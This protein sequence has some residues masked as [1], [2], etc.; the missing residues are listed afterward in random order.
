MRGRSAIAGGLALALVIIAGTRLLSDWPGAGGN[1]QG[2]GSP[3]AP[4]STP[5]PTWPTS[6]VPGHDLQTLPRFPNAVRTRYVETL[7]N[8]LTLT[9]VEYLA[10]TQ[11]QRLHDYYRAVFTKFGWVVADLEFSDE[12]RYFFVVNGDR[13]A[14]IQLRADDDARATVEISYSESAPGT[15]TLTP[16]QPS[17]SPTATP[18]ETPTVP[19][20]TATAPPAPTATMP[21]PPPTEAPPPPPPPDDGGDDDSEVQ[22]PPEDDD[23]DPDDDDGDND[24]DDTGDNDDDGGDDDD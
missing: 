21:P 22:P 6:D 12:R 15:V 13:E 8:D 16:L 3:T 14:S 19:A 4:V 23:D 1:A 11:L 20:P 18:G 7:R 2:D 10:D 24:D 9:Q 17:P 5:S